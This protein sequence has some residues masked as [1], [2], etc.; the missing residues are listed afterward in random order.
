MIKITCDRCE[1][2][3]DVDDD[4]AGTK[5]ECPECGDVNRVPEAV[6]ELVEEPAPETTRTP[7]RDRAEA[8]GLPPDSGP[9]V[10]VMKVRQAMFRARPLASFGVFVLRLGGL[11]L[12]LWMLI[13]NRMGWMSLG[14]VM[15]VAAL[16][17]LAVWWVKHL[18]V[19]LKITNKRT[20]SHR[21][22]FSRNTSEV[23]H[24]N[25]RNVTI[26]QSF[27]QRLWGVGRIGISS[28]GQDG[29]EIDV[30]K[31]RKPD[32]LRQIID[33]YRPLG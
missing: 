16:A 18:G 17:V 33:K 8:A 19:S 22:L 2:V 28:A 7:T 4:A 14:I 21:G 6:I 31:L 11:V 32:E 3:F 20:V 23:V 29:I 9:E 10:T 15:A 24:D 30:D 25:I 26:E 5:V 27:W 12:T 1:K 13:E